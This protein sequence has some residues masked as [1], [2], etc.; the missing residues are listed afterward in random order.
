MK[1]KLFLT[2]DHELPLGGLKTSYEA[3]LFEPTQK[4]MSLANKL[5]VPVTLF[6]DILCGYRFMEWDFNNFYTPYKNQLQHALKDGHD[7]QLHIHPHWLTTKYE[8]D[9]YLPSTDFSLSDFKENMLFDGIPGIIRQGINHIN[10]ICIP[11]NPN[12]KCI[13]YRAGGYNIAPDTSEIFRALYNQG[14]R[15]DSSMARGYYFKSEISE[16]DFR[17]LPNTA[18]WFVNPENYH[19][20]LISDGIL[21]VPIASIPKTPFEVPTMFKLKKYASRAPMNHGE[22][23][24]VN[25]QAD[26]IA[27]FN[28]LFSARMLSFDNYTLSLDYLL[29]IIQYNVKKIKSADTLMLSIIAH[30]KSMSDYSFKLMEGFVQSIYKNYP[31]AEFL[32]FTKFHEN[33]QNKAS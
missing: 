8:N 6:T 24:H 25:H 31:E 20:P 15:Y 23:I 29:R 27:K 10:N 4:V 30:P 12:Y 18:N 1:L 14:I 9:I 11:V 19:I 3:S 16:I 33:H 28:M 13:A 5:G 32:T 17:N 7:V 21:E 2:F 22:Q 26:K